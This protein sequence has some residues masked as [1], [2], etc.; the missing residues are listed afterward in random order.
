MWGVLH[1]GVTRPTVGKWRPGRPPSITLHQVEDVVVATQEQTP[2]QVEEPT[3]RA[4]RY[5]RSVDDGAAGDVDL[6][7]GHRRGAVGGDEGGDVGDVF[8]S[9]PAVEQG[10]VRLRVILGRVG[11]I[12]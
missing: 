2:A 11:W 5:V 3:L 8:E 10:D 9:R 6:G 1:R 4:A 12:G 7:G